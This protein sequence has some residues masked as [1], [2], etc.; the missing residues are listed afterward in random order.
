MQT[1]R[2]R[3]TPATLRFQRRAAGFRM[4]AGSD[5][6]FVGKEGHYPGA[7][8]E[9]SVVS[10]VERSRRGESWY[11]NNATTNW[12]FT[13]YERDAESGNDYAMARTT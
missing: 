3:R 12:M 2:Q 4:I 6:S 1:S 10:S 11:G 9:R 8:P 7:C 13:T 5:G